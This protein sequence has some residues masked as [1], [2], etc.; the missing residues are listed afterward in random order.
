MMIAFQIRVLNQLKISLINPHFCAKKDTGRGRK[1]TI[2]VMLR[3]RDEGTKVEKLPS[4]AVASIAS[5][6]HHVT[7]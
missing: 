2:Q 4:Q 6:C 7:S 5:H 3:R 1:S